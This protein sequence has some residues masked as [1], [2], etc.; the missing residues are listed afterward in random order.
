MTDMAAWLCGL[1][2]LIYL[3][4]DEPD[5][6]EELFEII[7]IGNLERMKVILYRGG[8]NGPVTVERDSSGEV[9]KA[10]TEALDV[11]A[12]GNGFILSPADGIHTTSD[13]TWSNVEGFIDT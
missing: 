9:R 2:P 5:L 4:A 7:A 1:Q 3:A 12:P 8:V 10:V 11:L 13:H 6:V